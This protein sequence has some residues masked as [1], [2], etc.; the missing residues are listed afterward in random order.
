MLSSFL[1]GGAYACFVEAIVL[2]ALVTWPLRYVAA[3]L[4]RRIKFLNDLEIY[5]MIQY[6]LI[7]TWLIW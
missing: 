2:V 6:S 3:S 5:K 1:L 4:A 7:S